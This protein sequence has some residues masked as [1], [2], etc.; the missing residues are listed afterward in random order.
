MKDSDIDIVAL[1]E[2]E[3]TKD[4]RYSI[5]D[6]LMA[7]EYKLGVLFDF[8]PMTTGEL[9]RNPIYFEEVTNNGVYYAGS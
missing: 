3:I 4:K 8:R 6:I 5:Y 7:I 2:D 9:E 1:F